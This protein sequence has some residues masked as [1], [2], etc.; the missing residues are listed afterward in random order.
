MSQ[1][2]PNPEE[3][4]RIV[5]DAVKHALKTAPKDE[6]QT[7]LDRLF[8]RFYSDCLRAKEAAQPFIDSGIQTNIIHTPKG[9][10]ETILAI[11]KAFLSVFKGYDKDEAVFLLAW[12]HANLICQEH[13]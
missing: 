1:S 11:H 8:Q 13:V 10:K 12:T 7:D 5:D 9:R 4:Q 6:V 3:K 2:N